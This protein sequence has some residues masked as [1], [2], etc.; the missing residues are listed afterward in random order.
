LRV[1]GERIVY[2][3]GVLEAKEQVADLYLIDG[4]MRYVEPNEYALLPLAA[5]DNVRAGPGGG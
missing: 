5:L 2:D 3:L 4:E 1:E